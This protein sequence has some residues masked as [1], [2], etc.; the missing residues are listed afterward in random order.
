MTALPTPDEL[1]ALP[2][3]A[4]PVRRD[5]WGRPMVPD[6]STGK[7]RAW[8][9]ATTL[10]S[11]IADRYGLEQWGKRM[12]VAGM[13]AKQRELVL[14]AVAAGDDKKALQAVADDA[15]AAAGAG[16]ARDAGSA[17][18]RIL[19]RR[20]LGEELE[21]PEPFTADVAAYDAAW[22]RH[23]LAVV[24]GWV[25]RFVVN[26]EL[27]AAG[28]P[29]LLVDW[30]ERP[31]EYV[32][33]ATPVIADIK[34]GR[35]IVEYGALEISAQLATYANASHWWDGEKLHPMPEVDKEVGIVL[36]MPAGRGTC[37][38]YAVDLVEGY[39]DAKLSYLVRARRKGASS[40][41]RQL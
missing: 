1:L 32:Q 2:E 7:V 41:F 17:L 11:T 24:P 20:A 10:A 39:K 13:A 3:V 5:G 15:L 26:T 8:T 38:A 33:D 16:D 4:V 22:Q 40:R 35:D 18:H 23:G 9:R 12:V 21:V 19:E 31:R 14:R 37:T 25:E 28:T 34:T 30:P 6:P 36:H 29:D 27:E